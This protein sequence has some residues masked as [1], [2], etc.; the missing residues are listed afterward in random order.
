M[1]IKNYRQALKEM[2]SQINRL[3][4]LSNYSPTHLEEACFV[5]LK[6]R[7]AMDKLR[8]SKRRS[9]LKMIKFVKRSK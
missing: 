2:K 4:V 8:N 3:T 7:I 9:T 1:R 6:S 5:F